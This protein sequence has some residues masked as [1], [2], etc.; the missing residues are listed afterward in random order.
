MMRE[1][2][3]WQ[4]II[5]P[6]M[7][8]LAVAL[9][10]QGCA[11]TYVAEIAMSDDRKRQGWSVPDLSGV[12]LRIADRESAVAELVHEAN[13]TSIHICQGIRDNGQVGFAQRRLAE[14]GLRQ[15]VVME[16]VWDSGVIGVLKRLEYRRLFARDDATLQGVLATG[17]QTTKWVVARGLPA[18]KVFPF[19][20]FLPDEQAVSG[21][22]REISGPYRFVFA[23]QL[24]PRKRLNWL[25]EGLSDLEGH[26]F[27]LWVVG[28]G[29][30]ELALRNL[31]ARKLG[32]RV[33]WLGQ[34]PLADVPN[35]MAQADCLVLPS[36]HDGWGAVASEAMI[37]GTPVVCSDACGVAGA[38]LASGVGGVFKVDDRLG[39]KDQ[40]A[41]HAA[42]GEVA[43]E[44]R[45]RL[46]AWA[47]CLGASAGAG[48]LLDIL[49][50]TDIHRVER[51]VPPWL[52]RMVPC[53]DLQY[54][55][56][57]L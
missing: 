25:I 5:S 31:A 18:E 49:D 15:W 19:A 13:A 35:V 29:E 51:P 7:A 38:V 8:G 45:A 33:R 34:L 22:D 39:L 24:I 23:G 47:K 21:N 41:R 52:K 3:L 4:H 14:R 12:N 42:K 26:S 48:Y 44:T 40:L 50:Y 2:W 27:E 17:H 37:Q 54:P 6:H 43:P 28:T 16:T 56:G 11:V 30:D 46:A 55:S 9:A 36:I 53:A 32:N 10:R 57:Q 1:V 20:Y